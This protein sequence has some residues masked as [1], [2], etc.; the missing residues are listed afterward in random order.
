MV[1]ARDGRRRARF[2]ATVPIK[3]RNAVKGHLNSGYAPGGK[4]SVADGGSLA[5]RRPFV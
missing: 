4:P 1:S 2:N 3:E 5:I